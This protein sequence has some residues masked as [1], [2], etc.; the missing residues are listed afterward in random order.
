MAGLTLLG[1][2]YP[3]LCPAPPPVIQQHPA[4]LTVVQ[5]APAAFTVTASGTAPL[6]Y[7]WRFNLANIPGAVSTNYT[8]ASA[9]FTNG[10]NHRSIL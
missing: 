5:G 9:Q 1:L 2:I 10:V 6:S 7:Q 3:L 4:S 8:L